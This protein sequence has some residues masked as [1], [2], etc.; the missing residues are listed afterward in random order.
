MM[1][2]ICT[3]MACKVFLEN[4]EPENTFVVFTHCDHPEAKKRVKFTTKKVESL[5]KASGIN[6]PKGNVILFDKTKESLEELV[7]S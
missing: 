5:R 1:E 3:A 6:I 7:A 4:L 2:E